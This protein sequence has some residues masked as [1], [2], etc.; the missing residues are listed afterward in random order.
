MMNLT[1]LREGAVQRCESQDVKFDRNRHLMFHQ[2]LVP[3]SVKIVRGPLLTIVGCRR[4]EDVKVKVSRLFPGLEV[5]TM[6][7]VAHGSVIRESDALDRVCAG[8]NDVLTVHWPAYIERFHSRVLPCRASIVDK[9]GEARSSGNRDE[10]RRVLKDASDQGHLSGEGQYGLFLIEHG[11]GGE[12]LREGIIHLKSAAD[13]GH[14][15]SVFQYGRYL[16]ERGEEDDL[17]DG[18]RYVREAADRGHCSAQFLYGQCLLNGRGVE[19][20]CVSA[21]EYLRLAAEHGHVGSMVECGICL[22]DGKIGIDPDLQ[23][24]ASYFQRAALLGDAAGQLYYGECL[25]DGLGVSV[26]VSGGLRSV[27]QSADQ[28]L[29]AGQYKYGICLFNGDD[30]TRDVAESSR[31]MKLAADQGHSNAQYQYGVCLRE[32]YGVTVDPAESARYMKLAADQGMAQAQFNYGIYLCEGYG[33]GVNPVESA[34]Y[35]K[36]AADQCDAGTARGRY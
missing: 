30:I 18:V 7:F 25:L 23:G 11:D 28:G 6:R 21:F 3:W 19:R 36:L 8:P 9:I 1:R 16:L 5:E 33:V 14:L 24:A 17:E 26:N 4:V 15:E 31:Y 10:L 12:D 27:K 34:R 32:G 22:R 2:L 13:R 20:H 29:A 35:M